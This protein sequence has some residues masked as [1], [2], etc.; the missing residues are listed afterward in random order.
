VSVYETREAWLNALARELRP[1]FV[2]QGFPIPEKV[3]L[4]C[5]FCS[6]GAASKRI[7]ECWSFERSATQ[8]VEIF[9]RPDQDD[10]LEV[11]GIALHELVHSALG[12]DKGHGPEF[13]SLATALGLEGKMTATTSGPKALALLGPIVDRLG[14]YPHGAL[15]LRGKKKEPKA[16]VWK[17][18]TCPDCGYSADVKI[19]HLEAGRLMCP[20]D[21]E[22]LMTKEERAER[23]A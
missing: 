12:N 18:V 1:A 15:S 10:T 8:H 11:A 6:T 3:R 9:I 19:V 2:D 7:G 23:E 4:S 16:Q 13:K 22:L 20:V 5:G 14:A 21:G 17:S